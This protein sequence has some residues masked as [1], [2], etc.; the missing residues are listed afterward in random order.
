MTQIPNYS[1]E[2]GPA[3]SAMATASMILGIIAL[4]L[5]CVVY[6][7]IPCAIV[8]LV[9]GLISLGKIKRGEA[10]G[11]G[12]AKAGAICSSIALGLDALIIVLGIIGLSLFGS[13][14]ATMQQQA[15]K[16]MQ[17]QQQAAQQQAAQQQAATQPASTPNP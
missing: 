11:P 14:V 17:M 1:S 7:S 4:E 8:G 15:I 9:L 6:L 2:R 5:F 12:M 16:Q 13:K 10:S 3:S